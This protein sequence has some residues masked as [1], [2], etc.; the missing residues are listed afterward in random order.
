MTEPTDQ[1]MAEDIESAIRAVPGVASIFRT[2]GILSKVADA[3]TQLFGAQ[4]NEAPLIRWEHGPEGR[5]VEAAIGVHA[6]AGATETSRRVQAA[7]AAMCAGR[8]YTSVEISLTVV[9]IDDG[10]EGQ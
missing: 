1:A 5:R 9:H 6:C 8:G 4:Q 3:R 10:P 2:G 7:I